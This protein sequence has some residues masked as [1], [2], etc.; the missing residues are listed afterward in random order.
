MK[1]RK[2]L[3]D[4]E[5]MLRMSNISLAISIIGLVITVTAFII[6]VVMAICK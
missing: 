3:T 4:S 2:E 5:Q 6:V 1:E